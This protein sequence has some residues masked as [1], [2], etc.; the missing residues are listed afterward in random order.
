MVCIMS[1]MFSCDIVVQFTHKTGTEYFS[2][3]CALNSSASS[4]V[5]SL[6]LSTIA[7]GLPVFFISSITRSSAFTYSSLVMSVILPSVVI[8]KPIVE[9]SVITF[10][11]PISAAWPKGIFSS[12]HGVATILGVSFSKCPK[13]PSTR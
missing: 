13:A 3:K 10:F 12:N 6:Q 4:E 1:F 11:V 8:T 5:G 2:A 7:K 9:C